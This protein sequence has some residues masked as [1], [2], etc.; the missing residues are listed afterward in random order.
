MINRS[1]LVGWDSSGME[2][3]VPS[4]VP[5]AT[6]R[7][8]R[9]ITILY[10]HYR[11]DYITHLRHTINRLGNLVTQFFTH[12]ESQNQTAFDHQGPDTWGEMSHLSECS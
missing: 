9:N 3:S 5:H 7:N 4:F 12:I 1:C 8:C 11:F 2:L 10:W 6:C